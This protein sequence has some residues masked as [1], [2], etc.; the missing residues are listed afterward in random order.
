MRCGLPASPRGGGVLEATRSARSTTR[1][2][3]GP[4]VSGQKT[5]LVRAPKTSASV[6]GGVVG[7]ALGTEELAA[8]QVSMALLSLVAFVLDAEAIAAQAMVGHALGAG[9]HGRVRTVVRRLIQHTVLAGLGSG[10]ILGD[11]ALCVATAV[12]AALLFYS[13]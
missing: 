11:D 13:H 4:S 6:I 1:D 3:I 8:L 12:R 2:G 7:A 10:L 9:D 5:R